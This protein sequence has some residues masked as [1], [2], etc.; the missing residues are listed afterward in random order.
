[1]RKKFKSRP[2]LAFTAEPSCLCEHLFLQSGIIHE[3]ESPDLFRPVFL[4]L[5][6]NCRLEPA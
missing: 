3:C 6:Q 5:E 2:D 1:M 4:L